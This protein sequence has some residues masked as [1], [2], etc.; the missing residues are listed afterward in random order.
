MSQACLLPDRPGPFAVASEVFVVL[1][2]HNIAAFVY[3]L[4]G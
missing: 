2:Y 1:S 3:L 4:H